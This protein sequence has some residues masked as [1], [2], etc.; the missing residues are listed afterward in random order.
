VICTFSLLFPPATVQQLL[1]GD[2]S[3]LTAPC[4]DGRGGHPLWMPATLYREVLALPASA[5]L[6]TLRER[7]PLQRIPVE[8]PGVLRDLDTPADFARALAELGQ[9]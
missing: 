6:R 3:Q 2:L 9:R 7:H 1:S 5:S 8:D 4:Y